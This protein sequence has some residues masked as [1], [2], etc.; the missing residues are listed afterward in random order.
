M[1]KSVLEA[2][3]TT[4]MERNEYNKLVSSLQNIN[5]FFFVKIKKCINKKKGMLTKK[6]SFFF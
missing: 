1:E 6:K 5:V 2:A 3:L 4:Y